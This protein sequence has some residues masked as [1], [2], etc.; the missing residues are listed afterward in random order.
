[1]SVGEMKDWKLELR[2]LHDSDTQVEGVGCEKNPWTCVYTRSGSM[3]MVLVIC[4]LWID[5]VRPTD[6][7]YMSVGGMK[8]MVVINLWCKGL[9]FKGCLWSLF[10]MNR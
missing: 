2:N 3:N 5:K 1:M 10:I 8:V 9:L 7:T 6:K 4:L